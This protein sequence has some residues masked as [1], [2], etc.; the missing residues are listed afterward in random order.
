MAPLCMCLCLWRGA[1]EAMEST[2]TQE[3][4]MRL[5]KLLLPIV[6]AFTMSVGPIIQPTR[7]PVMA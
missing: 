4:N 6:A 5:R 7:H 1:G 2:G 3:E